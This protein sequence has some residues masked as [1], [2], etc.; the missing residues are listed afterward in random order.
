MMETDPAFTTLSSEKTQTMN[1]VQNKSHVYCYTQSS[2]T[3]L[4]I[5]CLKMA[6]LCLKRDMNLLILT[7]NKHYLT[8]CMHLF[9]ESNYTTECNTAHTSHTI[10]YLFIPSFICSL[11]NDAI[12]NSDKEHQ[13]RR[14]YTLS[15]TSSRV[16]HILVMQT[17]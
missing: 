6:L 12:S 11:F 17:Y 4:N 7:V 1:N 9:N 14:Q 5:L 10:F 2:D 15:E 3:Q 8:V 16:H 13:I